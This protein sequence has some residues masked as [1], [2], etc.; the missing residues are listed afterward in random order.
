MNTIEE[1]FIND[2]TKE[3][4]CYVI[5]D[6]SHEKGMYEKI[7]KLK[8]LNTK[9]LFTGTPDEVS[10]KSGPL[11]VEITRNDIK[12]LDTF[13]RMEE[14]FHSV[15][16]IWSQFRFEKI[17]QLLKNILYINLLD[18]NEALCRYYDPRCI[19]YFVDFFLGKE[20]VKKDFIK[21]DFIAIF[22]GEADRYNTIKIKD[23]I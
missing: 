3:L 1:N 17:Y 2:A 15:V 4:K 7:S 10:Y 21:I 16:W 23:R 14:K 18:G 12:N 5:V 13:Y 8:I 19:S 11:L 6:C 22:N 20:E 9:S